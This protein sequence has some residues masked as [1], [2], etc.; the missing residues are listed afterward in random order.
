[1]GPRLFSVLVSG[2]VFAVTAQCQ[3]LKD[4]QN[5]WAD[6]LS[7]S[8]ANPPERGEV[9]LGPSKAGAAA[10]VPTVTFNRYLSLLVTDTDTVSAITF[11]AVM[12]QLAV[13]SGDPLFTKEMLFHQWWD[14]QNKQPGLD[15]G[16]HCDDIPP[17]DK[18]KLFAYD[19]P[20]MEGSQATEPNCV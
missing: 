6:Q 16:P 1:M 4:L 5:E 12:N 9:P 8:V 18:L 14:T 10:L 17:Q 15:L 11:S 2:H 19:C 20:R 3:D 7:K 13:Q